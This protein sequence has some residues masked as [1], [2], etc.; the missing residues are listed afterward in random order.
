ML[1]GSFLEPEAA[2]VLKIQLKK[3]FLDDNTVISELGCLINRTEPYIGYSPDG[4]VNDSCGGFLVEI[5]CPAHKNYKLRA[6]ELRGTPIYPLSLWPNGLSGHCPS[7][8]AKS[9]WACT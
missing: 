7:I 3:L 5:K 8:G 9:N 6:K 2:A 1:W 4:V